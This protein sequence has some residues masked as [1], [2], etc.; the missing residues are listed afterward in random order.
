M[1]KIFR[2]SVT[3]L[4]VT[5]AALACKNSKPLNNKTQ[6]DYTL[7]EASSQ[8]WV[9]GQQGHSSGTKYLIKL[10]VNKTP[11][12][13]NR[14]CVEGK[15]FP[16]QIIKNRK[17]VS[18]FEDITVGDTISVKANFINGQDFTICDS[19][20][21]AILTYQNANSTQQIHIKALTKK[22]KISRK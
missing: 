6:S 4:C 20:S 7:I 3:I 9:S 16:Y 13:P 15:S 21:A 2:K 11:F 5:V 19:N 1:N 18:R 12:S 17:L 22:Q 14:L 10:I 8:S